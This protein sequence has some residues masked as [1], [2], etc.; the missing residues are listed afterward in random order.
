M[1]WPCNQVKRRQFALNLVQASLGKCRRLEVF[2]RHRLSFHVLQPF[3]EFQRQQTAHCCLQLRPHFIHLLLQPESFAVLLSL[4]RQDFAFLQS[5]KRVQKALKG[6]TAAAD[7]VRFVR[8]KGSPPCRAV[9]GGGTRVCRVC[10]CS[11]HDH[12]LHHA[13]RHVQDAQQR[14]HHDFLRHGIGFVARGRQAQ[15][16]TKDDR[17]SRGGNRRGQLGGGGGRR[18]RGKQGR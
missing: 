14:L 12:S 9:E 6:A 17:V 8:E 10:S 16:E 7:P 13:K 2:G 1:N 18:G 3:R 4:C 11:S 15:G 5:P